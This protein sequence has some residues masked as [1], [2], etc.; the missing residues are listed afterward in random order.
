M[1]DSTSD[2]QL[3]HGLTCFVIGPIGSKLAPLGTDERLKWEDSIQIWEQVFEPACKHFGMQPI[4]ADKISQPGEITEQIFILL[5]DAEVVIADLTG[6]NA[7][8]MYEL[9]LR[10]TRDKITLQLGEYERLPFDVNTIRTIQYKRTEAALIDARDSLIAALRVALTSNGSPVTATRVWQDLGPIEPSTLADVSLISQEAD[11]DVEAF[12]PGAVD[13]MAEG[14]SAIFRLVELMDETSTRIKEIGTLMEE[15]GKKVG[16]S[17]NQG[18]GFAGRLLIAHEIA[19]SVATP[20]TALDELSNEYL[21]RLAS[22]DAAM[23][24]IIG[25]VETGSEDLDELREYLESIVGMADSAES[26]GP[27]LSTFL[28]SAKGLPK[29]SKVLAPVSK[30]LARS[31]SRILTGTGTITA[32]RERIK[33][34]PGW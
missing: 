27:G 23:D 20:V 1:S 8:V 31:V 4:R 7:N 18:K 13:I 21:T 15:G 12:E 16:E 19:D 22:L 25:R 11:V 24:Y 3:G 9:G 30:T 14:E 2:E 28:Q 26:A 17:D 6:G 33:A 34:L 5:R 32:W 29:L 10:H